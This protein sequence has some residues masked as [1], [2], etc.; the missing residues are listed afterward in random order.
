MKIFLKKENI[1]NY[2]VVSV[3]NG[4]T[5]IADAEEQDSN[6]KVSEWYMQKKRSI[7]QLKDLVS[8]KKE[9]KRSKHLRNNNFQYN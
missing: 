5:R 3:K 2:A 9:P 7:E 6:R 4:Q 1:E 8:G